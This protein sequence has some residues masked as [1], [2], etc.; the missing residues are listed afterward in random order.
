MVKKTVEQTFQKKSQLEHIKDLP[1]TYVGSVEKTELKVWILNAAEVME[2]V[3][4]EYVP[5][6]YKIFDEPLVNAIDHVIR[7][8]LDKSIKNKVNLIKVNINKKNGEISIYNNG[9]GLPVVIHKVHKTYIPEMVFGQLLTSANYDKK[10]KKITGGKNGYGAK[11]T[12]IFSTKFVV[13]TVDSNNGLKYVQVFENNMDKKGKP[14]ITKYS[15]KPYT[16]ITFI[17]DFERF[18]L[19]SLDEGTYQMM[20]K[21]VYDLT[22]CTGK[23]IT[24]YFDDKKINCKS[25]EK[26]VDYYLDNGIEKVYEYVSNRWEIVVAVNPEATFDQVSFVNGINTI[27]GGK[28]VDNVTTHIARKLQHIISTKG[29]KRKKLKIKQSYL[30]DQM[31]VFLRSTIENPSFDSQIKEYLTTPSS[32]FGSKFEISDK[33]IEKLLKTSIIDQALKLSE[34]KDSLTLNKKSGKKCS[35]LKGID[36]LD[37]ANKAGTK[38]ALNCTLIL[39]EGDSAK[40]L[41]VSGLSVVGRDYFGVFP[42]RGK[43]LNVRDSSIKRATSNKEIANIIKIMGLTITALK[44]KKNDIET[45]KSKLRYG[46]IMIFTDQDVDGSHIKGLLINLFH[47]FWPQL[48]RMDGFMISLAT[49]IVKAKYQKKILSFYT[50]TEYNKWKEKTA[51]VKKWNIKYYKGLGTSTSQE[52]KDYFTDFTKKK[53]EY[54][55]S[56]DDDKE[57]EQC[58]DAIGLAF[59]KTRANDRKY[60]LKTYD[61]KSIIEQNQKAVFYHEF[62]HKDLKHFSNYDNER[63]IPSM[64]DGFKP[65]HRKIIFSAFKKRMK[66]EIKVAQFAGYISEQTCYHHGENSLY[67]SIIGM[68]QNFVGSNNIEL[69]M[70][71]GQFGTRLQGGKDAGAP[72][73]I[74]TQQ[75]E[76]TSLVFNQL[77]NELLDYNYDDG[78]K[79]EPRWYIPILPWVLV[80]GAEG[81]GTGFSTKIPS[82]NPIDIVNNLLKLMDGKKL[83]I[84]KPWFRGFKGTI[85]F[86]CVNDYGNSI[87]YNIGVYNVI[88]D[89]TVEV[90]EL[91]IGTW[92]EDYKNFLDTLLFD[93]SSDAKS[94]KNQ[95]LVS[96]ESAY[97]ECT[98][99]FI[100]KFY[101]KDLK[102]YIE[103]NAL[104]NK[105]KLV[106]TRNTSLTNM[107]L[108]NSKGIITKYDS[109]EEILKEFYLIRLVF[110]IKRKEFLEKKLKRLL[111]IYEAKVKFI[112]EFISKDIDIINKEDEEVEAQLV[113][114]KYPKFSKNIN[115]ENTDDT[116]D[117][118]ATYDYLLSMQ[119]RSLTKK[120]IEE[121]KKLHEE[122]LAEYEALMK[123]SEKNMWKEDLKEFLKNYTK[124]LK[125]YEKIYCTQS[126]VKPTKSTGRKKTTRKKTTRKKTKKI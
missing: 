59:D 21:R 100:L 87:Y 17:P 109:A 72:R 50:M 49:P 80:N 58:N 78:I 85:N 41:A 84:M 61:E 7:T 43:L 51:N 47:V 102:E 33:F 67:S 9:E 122:K 6:L 42:L 105:L 60:W 36:K 91:P 70:P 68:A 38:E 106:D 65:V 24:I 104:Q 77:D 97:T 15:G 18:G 79:I 1:D 69:L 8:E 13:E 11:L 14:K 46:R 116:D 125:S 99:R 34:F 103:D 64:C 57:V 52:A 113:E 124:C 75:S 121:L 37:D 56:E 30:K 111:D 120:K 28:H 73:Y 83:T 96:Y 16:K 81:I 123:K 112:M 62:I 119:I 126:N 55:W 32:K 90:T 53:I 74:W 26:Y 76:L 4:L 107:H 20:K 2:K 10:E 63:S 66:H 12:N 110:Y 3:N 93:K 29:Y 27:K 114:R 19:K 86:K 82:F 108:Y 115:L 92:T 118:N 54:I 48:L 88:N 5:G 89:T 95:C 39:T 94:K 35:V 101:K 31:F 22:A 71:N 98:V 40:A 44:N 45:L 25:L 23:N 117:D